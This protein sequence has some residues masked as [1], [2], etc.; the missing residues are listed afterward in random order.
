MKL[1][2]T[3]GALAAAALTALAA[4]GLLGGVAGAK[5]PSNLTLK[6]AKGAL[7]VGAEVVA[8]SSD[9]TFETSAG[10]LECTTNV[11][12]GTLS[13]N[14]SKKDEGA[15]ASEHSSGG[16]PGGL[17]KTTTPLGP[18][19]ISTSNLPWATVLS[20]K[21][22]DEVKGKKV[23]FTATFPNEG[24]LKCTFE[25]AKVKS[26]FTIGGPVVLHTVKQKF[27]ANK[28]TSGTGCPKEGTLTGTFQGT[29][30]GETVEAELT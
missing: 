25:A 16:E 18:T 26:T 10:N 5:G 21:G 30:G 29:S 13:K 20:S 28:K 19:E 8:E 7:A 17:C 11:L 22:I 24:G 14:S 9:L 12:T 6:T 1:T 2:H 27:K 23:S 15:I 3:R 4:S